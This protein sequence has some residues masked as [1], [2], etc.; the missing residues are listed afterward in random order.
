MTAQS[1][2]IRAAVVQATS[3]AFDRERTLAKVAALI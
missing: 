1:R 2:V 3:S